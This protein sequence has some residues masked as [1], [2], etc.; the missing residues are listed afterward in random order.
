MHHITELKWLATSNTLTL[1]ECGLFWTGEEKVCVD[2]C[3]YYQAANGSLGKCTACWRAVW[4][5]GQVDL[6]H[7]LQESST[8]S[9]GQVLNLLQSECVMTE[10]IV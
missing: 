2:V 9:I 5:R 4:K 8:H 3:T 6:I 10:W 7:L 1:D